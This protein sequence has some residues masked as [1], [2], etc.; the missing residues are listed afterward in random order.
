MKKQYTTPRCSTVILDTQAII[1]TSGT[2]P[3]NV[4]TKNNTTSEW[5]NSNERYSNTIWE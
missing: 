3:Y 5:G 4:V 2:E 1:A